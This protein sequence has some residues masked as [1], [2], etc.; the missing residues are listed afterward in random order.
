MLINAIVK[1]NSTKILSKYSKL[2][3]GF[4]KLLQKNFSLVVKLFIILDTDGLGEK[5]LG[6]ILEL[7]MGVLFKVF[8]LN[9]TPDEMGAVQRTMRKLLASEATQKLIE[10]SAKDLNLFSAEGRNLFLANWY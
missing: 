7:P 4:V 3:S 10:I 6:R 8:S 2:H 1:L 5:I 9:L